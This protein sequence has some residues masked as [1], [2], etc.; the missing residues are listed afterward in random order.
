MVLFHHDKAK[1]PRRKT[2]AQGRGFSNTA[3][4]G[5]FQRVSTRSIVGNKPTA[6]G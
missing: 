5:V 4:N 3:T 2:P 1:T 6:E